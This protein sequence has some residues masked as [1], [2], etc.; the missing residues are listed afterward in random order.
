MSCFGL[1]RLFQPKSVALIGGSA[2]SSSLGGKVVQN[3]SGGGV[4]GDIVVVNP[5][6]GGGDA[7]K[8]YPALIVIPAPAPAVPDIIAEAGQLGVG[9]AVIISAGLGHGEGSLAE[10]VTR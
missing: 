10:A 8:T 6:H 4:A 1:E 7:F 9:G 5:Y 3:L 2:R